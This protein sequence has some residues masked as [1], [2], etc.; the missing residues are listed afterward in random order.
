MAV[1]ENS[2]IKIATTNN[3]HDFPFLFIETS[4]K[5]ARTGGRDY[6]LLLVGQ[7]LF[8]NCQAHT[9]AEQC[10]SSFDLG[11]ARVG[12]RDTQMRVIGIL[13]VGVGRAGTR[14]GQAAVL[15]QLGYALGAAGHD[16]Q[17]DEVTAL[18][19]RPVGDVAAGGQLLG[20]GGLDGV[21]AG[22]QAAAMLGHV[23]QDTGLILEKTDM[24]QLVHLVVA[25][26]H[27]REALAHVLHRVLAASD[28]GD[29]R[30]REGDLARGGEHKD[31]VLIAVLLGFVQ[32]N[33]RL[34][35]LIGQVVDDVRLIPEDLEIGGSGLE[36]GK[37]ADRLVAVGVAVGVG[38]LRH[39][40]DALDGV[41][42]G[43]ELFNHVHVGA[44][45]AHGHGDQLKA[46][47]LGDGKVAVIAGHGAEE[48]AVLDLAPGLRG[49]L[50]TE[51]HADG[52]QVVHQLQA[53]VAAHEKLAGNLNN[54]NVPG[55][56][57]R[58]MYLKPFY[59]VGKGELLQG[60]QVHIM[61]F[62]KAPL[63]EIQFLVM[64]EVAALYPDRAVFDHADK[65]RFSMFD[66]V[67]GSKQIRERFS[68]RNRWEDVRDY[69]YKDVENFR[70]LSKQYYLYK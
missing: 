36:R 3:G 4:K 49:I 40:P 64:Q 68:K 10:R 42:L 52:D 24:A 41:I 70:K 1:R 15:A 18:G 16:V 44:V 66:K 12:R 54:L 33:R 37:A 45:G 11:Q 20:K 9:D 8:N 23:G 65:G 55:V 25:D 2:T 46:H 6:I 48:L 61:D 17:A 53:G 29:A 39:T 19:V 35:D 14:Q 34:D 28:G 5:L 59:S 21:K 30:A 47:L 67:S 43:D 27:R 63:S 57:F 62:G 56:I 58:P 32:Q 60:V 26:D 69:W 7:Q 38:I 51:H 31:T 22:H 50:E 13:V